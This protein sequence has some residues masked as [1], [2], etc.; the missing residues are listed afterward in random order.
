MRLKFIMVVTLSRCCSQ[1][2]LFCSSVSL[3]NVSI[4]VC[5][6]QGKDGAVTCVAGEHWEAGASP[7]PLGRTGPAVSWLSGGGTLPS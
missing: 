6:F 5:L 2:R 4:L 3:R 7:W 1:C